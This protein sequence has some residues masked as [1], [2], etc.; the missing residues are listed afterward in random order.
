DSSGNL[1]VADTGNNRVRR[2]S[3]GTI[4]TV[5]GNGTPGSSGDG[6]PA[7]SAGVGNPVSVAL[8]TPGDLYIGQSFNESD[9]TAGDIRK[10][11][12]G[13]I[14][15]L[16]FVDVAIGIASD[17]A[18]NVFAAYPSGAIV[19]E[20]TNKGV[21]IFSVA[22]T[23]GTEG[24]GGDNGPATGALLN[25]PSGVAVDASGNLYIADA[26]NNRV[27]KVSNGTITTIAGNGTAGSTGDGGQATSAEL[28]SPLVVAVTPVGNVY[29]VES[30]QR[31][32]KVS[33]A[34]GI[35]STLIG[36][37]ATGSSGDGG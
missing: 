1:Y 7:T 5:A 34:N 13:V 27:R 22:G 32:R 30:G 37:G 28:D 15:T 14:S 21:F 33:A 25:E 16:G 26:A 24:Y 9:F 6:G 2:I 31:V 4:T 23:L 8:D 17:T 3:N 20:L 29:I 11:S 12:G 36:T 10:V 19:E 35:I 18:G